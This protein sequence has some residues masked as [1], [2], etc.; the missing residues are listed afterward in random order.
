MAVKH[1]FY[2]K[3]NPLQNQLFKFQAEKILIDFKNAGAGQGSDAGPG[4]GP[5]Y[6]PP[7]EVV[8]IDFLTNFLDSETPKT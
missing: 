4:T 5:N 1:T 8:K 2:N 7:P 3:E 6:P